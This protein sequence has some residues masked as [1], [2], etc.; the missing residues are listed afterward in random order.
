MVYESFGLFR[1]LYQNLRTEL[2][3]RPILPPA[4]QGGEAEAGE[5]VPL[6]AETREGEVGE[7]VEGK[8]IAAAWKGPRA[9][10]LERFLHFLAPKRAVKEVVRASVVR[11]GWLLPIRD[12]RKKPWQPTQ[13]R[14]GGRRLSAAAGDDLD[15]APGGEWGA[16]SL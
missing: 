14:S 13:A 7:D 9:L 2:A 4:P 6:A 10:G 8:G 11:S 5:N 12:H 15:D 3:N 1:K 16:P